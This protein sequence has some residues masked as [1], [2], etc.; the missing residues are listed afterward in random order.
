MHPAFI[1]NCDLLIASHDLRVGQ[2]SRWI[3][4]EEIKYAYE[5]EIREIK[6]KKFRAAS[7]HK[8]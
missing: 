1:S 3:A 7:T 6:R 8:G 4:D 5:V 2:A